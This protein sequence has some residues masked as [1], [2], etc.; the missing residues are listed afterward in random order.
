MAAG[1]FLSDFLYQ[2]DSK[3][4]KISKSDFAKSL[5][6]DSV[7]IGE[8]VVNVLGNFGVAGFRFHLPETEQITMQNDITDHFVETNSAVQDHIARHPTIVTLSGLQGEY[9]YS[10][11]EIEDLLATITPTLSLVK[12]FLPKIAPSTQQ[13][14]TQKATQ[15]NAVTQEKELIVGGVEVQKRQFNAMDLFKLFQ[16]LYK[17]KSAQTRAYYFFEA[18]FKSRAIM[19]IETSW[20]RLDNMVIQNVQAIRDG[21][22]DITEFMLTFKQLSITESGV[23]KIENTAGRLAQQSAPVTNKGVDK[24]QEVKAV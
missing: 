14:K 12:Q 22:A 8:A 4:S 10:V 5:F 13:N 9:F 17:L 16:D 24:G 18:L 6:K 1:E 3:Y 23:E 21:N 2:V 19:S 7:N 15:E 20:R 11:N